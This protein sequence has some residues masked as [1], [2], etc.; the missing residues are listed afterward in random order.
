MVCPNQPGKFVNKSQTHKSVGS[1]SPKEPLVPCPWLQLFPADRDKV[2]F[3]EVGFLPVAYQ[4]APGL[5][6]LR[7]PILRG[8]L[9]PIA[10][11]FGDQRHSQPVILS[12]PVVTSLLPHGSPAHHP[13]YPDLSIPLWK[14]LLLFPE[15]TYQSHRQHRILRHLRK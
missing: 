9:L 7:F 1:I 5:C 15:D 11:F 10:V 12:V 4:S 2:V 13:S 14:P 3:S 8:L 6:A